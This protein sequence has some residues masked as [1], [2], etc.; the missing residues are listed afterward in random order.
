[1]NIL[2]SVV[3]PIY[4]SEKHLAQCLESILAQNITDSYEI[5]CVNDGSHDH[6]INILNEYAEKFN[7]IIIVNQKNGGANAARKK[8][9]ERSNGEWILFV[10]SDDSLPFDALKN[11]SLGISEK[12]DIII[13]E[14]HGSKKVKIVSNQEYRI[15]L[16]KGIIPTSPVARL[17]RR[18][19]FNHETLAIPKQLVYGE[20]MLM[21]IRIAFQTHND[22]NFIGKKVYNYSINQQSVSHT[23][24]KTPEYEEAFHRYLCNSLPEKERD[25]RIYRHAHIYNMINAWKCLNL[26]SLS[27]K[28]RRKSEFYKNLI[29]EIE[30]QKYNTCWQERIQIH[31]HSYLLRIIAIFMNFIPI[32]K[33]RIQHMFNCSY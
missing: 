10:D 9:V 22:V 7:N 17:F 29:I 33:F 21:N 14:I 32:V 19:I 18:K 11:L 2:I 1:M 6:S 31:G 25:M 13:G 28:K 27:T 24:I 30:K 15:G 3:I 20:D 4:N 26:F 23:F 8:G 16:I 12:F 5:V